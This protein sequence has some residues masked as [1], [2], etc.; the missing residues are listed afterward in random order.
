MKVHEQIAVCEICESGD[1]QL[2]LYDFGLQ[3]QLPD[4]TALTVAPPH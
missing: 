3:H 4:A 1:F 2:A